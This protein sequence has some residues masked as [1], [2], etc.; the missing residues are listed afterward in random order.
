[1]KISKRDLA[2][3]SNTKF[4]NKKEDIFAP[5]FTDSLLTPEGK[6]LLAVL[7]T[8]RGV[9][10]SENKENVLH[11]AKEENPFRFSYS[12]MDLQ[13]QKSNGMPIMVR[14]SSIHVRFEEWEQDVLSHPELQGGQLPRDITDL[15]FIF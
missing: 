11:I 7:K 12:F 5:G 1:M 9:F 3:L 14:I 8:A 2:Y 6:R 10:V 15:E 13:D 4:V